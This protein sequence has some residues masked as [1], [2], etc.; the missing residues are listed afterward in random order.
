MLRVHRARRREA[1]GRPADPAARRQPGAAHGR[2]ALA[3]P[4]HQGQRPGADAAD[5]EEEPDRPRG[6]R[7]S[8][9]AAAGLARGAA[10]SAIEQ[11]SARGTAVAGAAEEVRAR[12][13]AGGHRAQA[14]A[15]RARQRAGSRRARSWPGSTSRSRS[16]A[17]TSAKRARQLDLASPRADR[18][19]V[20]TWVI[21]EEGVSVT[22][23][24]ALARVAD[25]ASFRVD[26]NVSDVHAKRLVVGQ[27]ATVRIGDERLD[28]TVAAINPTVSQRRDHRRHR[29]GRA[30]Q[31]AAAIEPA[32]RRRDRHGAPAAD[33]A[34]APRAVCHRRGH[35]AGVRRARRRASSASR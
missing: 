20:L 1:G 22:K 7:R 4:G 13:G 30:L 23:G 17:A 2:Q 27:P 16:C 26:A 10:R 28:G 34:R 31:P 25:F 21:T 14:A 11:L 29:P 19:G 18:A 6:P 5:A 15:R 9:G 3:G 35:A 8:E 12:D 32:R 24:Q 33:A